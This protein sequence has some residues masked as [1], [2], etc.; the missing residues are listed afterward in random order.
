M[1]SEQKKRAL[2]AEVLNKTEVA[3]RESVDGM[4]QAVSEFEKLSQLASVL[5]QDTS[6]G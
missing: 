1:A 5:A 2:S 3:L 6:N 4:T